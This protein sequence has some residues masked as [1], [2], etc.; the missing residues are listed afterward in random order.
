MSFPSRRRLF[1]ALFAVMLVLG[2]VGPVVVTSEIAS[3][4]TGGV[5]GATSG[6]DA[7]PFAATT[8]TDNESTQHE[9]PDEA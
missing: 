4:S 3:A 5:A 8:P 9:N 6:A 1:V 7:A 2:A